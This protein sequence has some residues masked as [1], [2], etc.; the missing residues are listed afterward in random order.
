MKDTDNKRN[1]E[2]IESKDYDTLIKENERVIYYVLKQFKIPLEDQEDLIQECKIRLYI[3]ATMYDV[4]KGSFSG[5]AFKS[6]Y[7]CIKLYFRA[8]NK[9]D[10]I[11]FNSISLDKNLDT[12]NGV[13]G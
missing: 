9:N 12:D 2:L 4:S 8:K 1:L 6:V 7:N 5:Y 11:Y 10:I 13:N 3:A